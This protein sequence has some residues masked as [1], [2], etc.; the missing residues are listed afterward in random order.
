MQDLQTLMQKL[1]FSHGDME[2]VNFMPSNFSEYIHCLSHLQTEEQ[3][4]PW[5]SLETQ[6]ASTHAAISC[7]TMPCKQTGYHTITQLFHCSDHYFVVYHIS[8]RTAFVPFSSYK[9]CISEEAILYQGFW[10]LLTLKVHCDLIQCKSSLCLSVMN[11]HMGWVIVRA[12]EFPC[13]TAANYSRNV[14]STCTESAAS[15]LHHK[16]RYTGVFC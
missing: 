10:I 14:W 15:H 13:H 9:I 5:L 16:H 1:E 7:A 4:S 8:R 3:A 11:L 2:C 12:S 6:A